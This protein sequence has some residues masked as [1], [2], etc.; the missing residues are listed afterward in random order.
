MRLPFRTKVMILLV[1]VVTCLIIV[2]VNLRFKLYGLNKKVQREVAQTAVNTYPRDAMP[3]IRMPANHKSGVVSKNVIMVWSNGDGTVG[4][5]DLSWDDIAK[6]QRLARS[7]STDEYEEMIA[8]A[9]LQTTVEF[10]S[11]VELKLSTSQVA[12]NRIKQ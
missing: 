10:L 11:S 3:P 12:E 7:V 4:A 5:H 2:I 9:Q 6:L 8:R 1:L